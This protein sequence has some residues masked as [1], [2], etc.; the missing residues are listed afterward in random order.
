VAKVYSAVEGSLAED[1]EAG[2]KGNWPPD[3]AVLQQRGRSDR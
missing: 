1:K 2:R 3:G